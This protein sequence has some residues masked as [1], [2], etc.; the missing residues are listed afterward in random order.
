MWSGESRLRS[1]FSRERTA[2]YA[3]SQESDCPYQRKRA[4]LFNINKENATFIAPLF[5]EVHQ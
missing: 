1:E 2:H 3:L 5:H 4:S